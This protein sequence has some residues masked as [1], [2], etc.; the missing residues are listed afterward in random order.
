M[1]LIPVSGPGHLLPRK[2]QLKKAQR[3][4]QACNALRH[5]E[6]PVGDFITNAL[7]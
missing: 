6:L 7:H 1:Q 4:T 5:M 2:E 3:N